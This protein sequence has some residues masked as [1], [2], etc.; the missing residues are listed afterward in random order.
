MEGV[1]RLINKKTEV[2]NALKG[3]GS[4]ETLE[5]MTFAQCK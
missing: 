5:N 3:T 1:R 2:G 4:R